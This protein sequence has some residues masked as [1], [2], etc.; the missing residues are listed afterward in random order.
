VLEAPVE[1]GKTG[2]RMAPARMPLCTLPLAST[3]SAQAMTFT[4]LNRPLI[5]NRPHMD[6]GASI[7]LDYG[8]LATALDAPLCRAALFLEGACGCPVLQA[9]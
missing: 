4:C 3:E 2:Q 5:G 1:R 7:T 8:L 6:N 9:S